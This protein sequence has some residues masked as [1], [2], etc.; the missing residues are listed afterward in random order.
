MSTNDGMPVRPEDQNKKDESGVSDVAELGLDGVS[1]MLDGSLQA[2]PTPAV[3]GET[4]SEALT[5]TGDAAGTAID[6][7]IA[8]AEAGASVGDV[9]EGVLN[10]VG[11]LFDAS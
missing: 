5:A 9:A 6:A 4:V 1:A 8:G 3:V 2:S 10:I 7:V 11:G